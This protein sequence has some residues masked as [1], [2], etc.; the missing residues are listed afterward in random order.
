MRLLT[1]KIFGW[2]TGNPCKNKGRLL[3]TLYLIETGSPE[4]NRY[5]CG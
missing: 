1:K 4:W 2:P 5:F 3:P